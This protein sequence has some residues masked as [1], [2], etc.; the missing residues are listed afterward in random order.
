MRPRI[1]LPAVGWSPKKLV[2]VSQDIRQLLAESGVSPMHVV[3]EDMDAAPPPAPTYLHL[4][5]VECEIEWYA[6]AF[7]ACQRCASKGTVHKATI[8]RVT[9]PEG[10]AL[11]AIVEKV[12]A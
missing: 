10:V 1:T 11:G 12:E 5:C 7:S 3:I 9:L 2:M 4:K 6:E 8:K